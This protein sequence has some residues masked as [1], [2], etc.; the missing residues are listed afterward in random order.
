[1][2]RMKKIGP[3]A[4][5]AAAFIGPGTITSASFAGSSYGF[6]LAWAVLFSTFATFILQEMAMRL[7]IIGQKGLGEAMRYKISHPLLKSIVILIII[8]A[9]VIG[10]AAYEA[11][12][13]SGAALGFEVNLIP[14]YGFTLNPMVLGIGLLAGLILLLGD[15]RF[16]TKF[17]MACV[18]V[19]GFVF[20]VSAIALKPDMRELI[21]SMF[22]PQIPKGSLKLVLALIGTTV[23]PYNLFLHTS[24]SKNNWNE[25][26]DLPFARK[27]ALIS[28]FL[29]G[30]ITLSIL[31]A[32]AL[33]KTQT[34][35]SIESLPQMAKNIS[36]VLGDWSAQFMALGF[37]AAGLSSAITAPMAAALV[38]CELF[39]WSK[40]RSK[41]GYRSIWLLIITL[42]IVF[43]SLGFKP[44][45]IIIFAQFANGLLLP[46]I[47]GFLLWVVNDHGLLKKNTNSTFENLCGIL[48]I[49]VAM[50][51]GVKSIFYLFN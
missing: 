51:L 50:I 10:N 7:G 29:G 34:G 31:I 9:I 2:S 27:D 41:I 14:I 45:A 21:K 15:A 30:L 48:V 47:A 46:I 42:G 26:S 35:A 5:V 43:S 19:M 11:G 8:S 37:L 25:A 6:T 32:A 22:S 23:V 44:T 3:G 40:D 18:G 20:I 24:V 17:L 16:I 13:I 12:N 33:V 28:I 38:A 49:I 39:G 1:M 36:P 4:V